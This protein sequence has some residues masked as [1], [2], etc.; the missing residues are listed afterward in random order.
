MGGNVL[1]VLGTCLDF[2]SLRF[3]GGLRFP[4]DSQLGRLST[5]W[6]IHEQL[7]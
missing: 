6:Y 4:S 7:L 1:A 3:A 2:V 5:S